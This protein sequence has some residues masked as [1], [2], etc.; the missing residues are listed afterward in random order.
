MIKI[1]VA[2]NHPLV[3][4]SLTEIL[5]RE[6]DMRVTGEAENSQQVSE[7]VKQTGPNV[8]I[9]SLSLEGKETLNMIK[10]LNRLHPRLSVLVLTMHPADHFASRTLSAGASGF[11]T[12]DVPPED[13]IRAVRTVVKGE[14]YIPPSLAERLGTEG[15]NSF[16]PRP[17][18]P[19]T[20]KEVQV[21]NALATGKSVA[22][23]ASDLSMTVYSVSSC[24]RMIFKKL[25]VRTTPELISYAADNKSGN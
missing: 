2:D 3:R 13:I 16:V 4:K 1:V 21:L 24:R 10:D 18:E 23:I 12:K 25:N 20:E 9:T 7:R 6:A 19:L 11:L 15:P 14:K 22:K 8:L 17:Q 5:E